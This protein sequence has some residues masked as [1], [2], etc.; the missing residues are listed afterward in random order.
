MKNLFK[1][2]LI[3][4]ALSA[5]AA[6]ADF[7]GG[8]AIALWNIAENGGSVDT[9]GAPGSVSLVSNNVGTTNANQD[10]TFTAF[11]NATITFDWSYSTV[12]TAT[13]TTQGAQWDPFGYLHAG[14]FTQLTD[15]AG[16]DSQN[17][18]VSFD[19]IIGEVFGFRSNTVDGIAGAAT[20]SVMNFAANAPSPAVVPLPPAAWLMGAAVGGLLLVPQRSKKALLPV[21]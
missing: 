7:S 16:A 12:D 13:A 6:Y 14:S 4:T 9:S 3:T 17:G 15:N 1:A 10:L 21:A 19:V 20:T 11:E 5:P 8:Y 2:A 18:S